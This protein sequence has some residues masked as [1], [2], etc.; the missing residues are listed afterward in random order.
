M[1]A[2]Q[3]DNDIT[4]WSPQGRIHQIEYAM[5]AVKQGSACLGLK[6]KTHAV[7]CTI[8][9]LP[10]KLASYQKKIFKIDQHMGIAIA[11]LTS[12]ARVL[13]RYMRTECLNYKYVYDSPMNVGRLVLQLA[14][15]SQKNTHR[16]GRRPYGVGM[17]V[18]GYD[19][20]GAHL[21][22]TCP[23]GN[24]FDY[25][26]IAIG[27]RSQ[28]A[29][30]YLERL[31]D[32]EKK[33][34]ELDNASLEDLIKHALLALQETLST[35]DE[36]GLTTAN[37]SLALVGIDRKFEELEGAQLQQAIETALAEGGKKKKTSEEGSTAMA[38]DSITS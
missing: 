16:S 17:L 13:S 6:S 10:A 30:T 5:E 7:I 31:F 24:Y 9:R 1:L 18:I 19:D 12:D 11:G 26:A 2:T 29:K 3:Y 21:F 33:T 15:K 14:D 36:E 34:N 4:T 23:S 32:A 22:E 20:S 25:K 27:A 8:K 37:V 35:S 28:S 38:T